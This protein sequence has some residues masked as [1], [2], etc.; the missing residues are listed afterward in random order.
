MNDLQSKVNLV[1][2]TQQN[3]ARNQPTGGATGGGAGGYDFTKHANELK[4]IMHVVQ[5]DMRTLS[6]KQ[7]VSHLIRNETKKKNMKIIVR[8]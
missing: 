7:T 8:I 6:S 2:Q 4:D 5:N 3:M 1:Q